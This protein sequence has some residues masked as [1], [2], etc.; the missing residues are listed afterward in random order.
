MLN[1]ACCLISIEGSDGA[2]KATQTKLLVDKLKSMG[3]RVATMSFPHYKSPTGLRIRNMLNTDEHKTISMMDRIALYA[4]D[5]LASRASIYS[6]MLENDYIILDRY[7]ESMVIYGQALVYDKPGFFECAKSTD[8][9]SRS[10]I[11]TFIQRLEYGI[12]KMP[13]PTLNINL[14]VPSSVS[15]T[16]AKARG[17]LDGN[18]ADASLQKNVVE[19]MLEYKEPPTYAARRTSDFLCENVLCAD[20]I[21]DMYKPEAIHEEI[22]RQL[23]KNDLI[24]PDLDNTVPINPAIKQQFSSELL[25]P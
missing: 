1:M 15:M 4:E 9:R 8:F 11:A 5:R 18:E 13:L 20:L 21:E 14:I 17:E 19:V 10:D 23:V 3:Y 22:M 16:N 25:F 2:G 24:I 6:M 12:N 7:V